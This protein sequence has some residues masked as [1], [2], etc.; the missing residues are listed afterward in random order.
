MNF[1]ENKNK[2]LIYSIFGEF[3]LRHISKRRKKN[4]RWHQKSAPKE[5]LM[6]NSILNSKPLYVLRTFSYSHSVTLHFMVRCRDITIYLKLKCITDNS[7]HFMNKKQSG[8]LCLFFL[9]PTAQ[10]CSLT[11]LFVTRI[12]YHTNNAC[13]FAHYCALEKWS[14]CIML[15]KTK[16]KTK[17]E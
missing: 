1:S 9:S 15:H 7:M 10:L 3:R 11:Q 13:A 4:R 8:F 17:R 5:N 2:T 12:Y 16:W 6:K 14:E